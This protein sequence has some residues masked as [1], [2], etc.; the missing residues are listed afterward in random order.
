MLTNMSDGL[1]IRCLNQTD[2]HVMA[3]A[4]SSIGWFKPAALF[5]RYLVEQASGTRLCWVADLDSAFTGYVTVN[6]QPTYPGFAEKQIPEIQDLN[7]L[8]CFR[9]KGIG[10][11]LLDQAERQIACGSEIAGIGVGLHPGY[12]DAQKLYGRRGYFPDGRGVTYRNR[13][14]HEGEYVIVD[15]ELLLH[16]I[17]RIRP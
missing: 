2:P 16:L 1:Q 4:F 7:V 11:A 5:Q 12:N 10:T 15:D 14:V 6:W 3:A 8:P 17:R 9:R 13:Y